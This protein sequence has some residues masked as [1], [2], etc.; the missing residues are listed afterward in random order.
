MGNGEEIFK[1]LITKNKEY[2]INIKMLRDGIYYQKF[3][4]QI[5]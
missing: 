2:L 5:L 1:F 4:V 3:P